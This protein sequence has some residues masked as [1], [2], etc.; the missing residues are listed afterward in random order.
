MNSSGHFLTRQEVRE[1]DRRA[2]LEFGVPGLVLMENAGRGTA[3]LLV[4]LGISGPVHLVCGKGNNGG[5]GFVIARHL[6]LRGVPVIIH[7]CAPS[8]KFSGDAATN[9]EIVHRARF[10]M[11]PFTTASALAERLKEADWIVDALLGTGLSGTVQSPEREVIECL[12]GSGRRILA[13][14]LP[15]GLDTDTGLP[16]GVAVRA[17]HTAT[18]VAL[19][20]GFAVPGAKAWTGEVHII[21][22][23]APRLLLRD[24]LE[25]AMSQQRIP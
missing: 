19:K 1:L 18:M 8:D 16:L 24:Y 6:D 9:Y 12:N 5:D 13:V 23:G 4:R 20:Q 21:D 7:L 11:E 17:E 15:S 10:Q 3:E 14:D 25:G 2:I 22:I